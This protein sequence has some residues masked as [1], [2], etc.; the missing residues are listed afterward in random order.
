MVNDTYDSRHVHEPEIVPQLDAEGRCLI[1]GLICERDERDRQIARLRAEVELQVR[2]MGEFAERSEDDMNTLRA[3][4]ERLTDCERVAAE[5]VTELMALRSVRDAVWPLYEMSK[6]P[7]PNDPER[8]A[9]RHWPVWEACAAL[10]A[11]MT[12]RRQ[13]MEA[14]FTLQYRLPDPVIDTGA[15]GQVRTNGVPTWELHTHEFKLVFSSAE[16]LDE[17]LQPYDED[18]EKSGWLMHWVPTLAEQKV[19]ALG[20]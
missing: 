11:A 2:Q 13:I 20:R 1:C 10:D 19:R 5:T 12:T 7:M 8:W 14:V 15:D 4:I 18:V 3:E 16:E 17:L 6:E 9:K